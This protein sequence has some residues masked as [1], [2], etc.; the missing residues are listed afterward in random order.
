MA[1]IK[2]YIPQNK[3]INIHYKPCSI[4]Y[5]GNLSGQKYLTSTLAYRTQCSQE[6]MLIKEEKRL[7][8]KKY[9]NKVLKLYL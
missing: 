6:K 2:Q 9:G 7:L 1:E 8:G 5:Y 4:T 3:V